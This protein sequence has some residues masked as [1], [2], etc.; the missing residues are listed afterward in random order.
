[1]MG[2]DPP[3][4]DARATPAP[5]TR[6]RSER[7]PVE[8]ATPATVDAG[9]A[10]F[11]LAP[12]LTRLENSILRSVDPPLTFR[13]YRILHRVAEGR[14]SLTALG[15]LATITLPAISESVDVLV[16]KGLLLRGTSDADRRAV[17]LRLTDEGER[18]RAQAATLLEQAAWRLLEDVDPARR[19]E[20]AEAI[21]LITAHV[22]E[23]LVTPS[24]GE[25]NPASDRPH[26]PGGS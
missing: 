3:G 19:G 16:R 25:G 5:T 14:T 6:Q 1:M 18:A 22:T 12:R 21:R 23:A 9:L 17:E 26:P 13:Q 7:S 24:D 8:D 10:L 2:A 20:L 15:K 11:E 4:G